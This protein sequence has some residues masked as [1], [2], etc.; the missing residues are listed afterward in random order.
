MPAEQTNGIAPEQR[1][2]IGISFGNSNSSIAIKG[3]DD[4]VEVIAN[5][6]GGKKDSIYDGNLCWTL[7]LT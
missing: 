2:A 6:D 7:S 3:S 5:E 1:H 4:K